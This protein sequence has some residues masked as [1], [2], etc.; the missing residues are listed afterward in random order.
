MTVRVY[1]SHV[2]EDIEL[3]SDL[4]ELLESSLGL[5][6]VELGCTSLPGYA[7]GDQAAAD[8][9]VVVALVSER[10]V[11]SFQLGFEIGAAWSRRKRIV[12]LADVY[13]ALRAKRAYK[14]AFCHERARDVILNGD[15]R[16][17]PTAHFDPALLA[18]FAEHHA[19]LDTVWNAFHA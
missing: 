15:E 4:V 10:S 12:A 7:T 6:Q 14:P 17:D 3:A 9:Q 19:E 18:I 5:E 8:A 16:L 11:R 2:R 13:D 1:V